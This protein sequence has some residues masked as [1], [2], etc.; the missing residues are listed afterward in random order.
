MTQDNRALPDLPW[1]L[2]IV[3]PCAFGRAGLMAAL[4]DERSVGATP[5]IAVASLSAARQLW[6]ASLPM[7]GQQPA[8]G[9]KE[10]CL[11]IRMPAAP[12]AALALLLEL[13]SPAVRTL[14]ARWVT[15]LLTSVPAP[16]VRGLL[17][18]TGGDLSMRV[19]DGSQPVARL[20]RAV[21]AACRASACAW[22]DIRHVATNPT[23]PALSARECRVLLLTLQGVAI[24]ELARRDAISH[25]TLYSQRHNAL[26]KLGVRGMQGLLL[27]FAGAPQVARS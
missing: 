22:D 24:A 25:K 15:V 17:A 14:F 11:V 20:R 12:R 2:M 13:S 21:L 1:Q 8:T 18:A 7:P 9:G 6:R 16:R 5:L 10:G 19:V 27:L 26:L 23:A 3:D 4:S